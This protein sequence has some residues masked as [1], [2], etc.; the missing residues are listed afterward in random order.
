MV[1]PVTNGPLYTRTR[2]CTD[3]YLNGTRQFLK[4][5]T[6]NQRQKK[7]FNLPLGYACE[8]EEWKILARPDPVWGAIVNPRLAYDNGNNAVTNAATVAFGKFREACYG[9][10]AGWAVSVVQYRQTFDML[11]SNLLTLRNVV[12]HLSRYK[13]S[14]VRALHRML[15]PPP[16]FKSKAKTVAGRWLEWSFGIKP[17]LQDIG[18]SVEALKRDFD[19]K[20]VKV[21]GKGKYA[22]SGSQFLQTSVYQDYRG[23]ATQK[24]VMGGTITVTNPNALLWTSLGLTNPLAVV[25]D[26]IPYSFVLNYFISIEP[27]IQGLSP[28]YGVSL[29]N[30]YTSTKTSYSGIVLSRGDSPNT[31]VANRGKRVMTSGS[32]ETFTRAPGALATPPLRVR[33][34]WIISPTRAANAISLL[35]QQLKR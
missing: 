5:V 4:Q 15:K 21:H 27:W 32:R 19:T 23:V 1:A 26:A 6:V 2:A 22:Y 20:H 34:P 10:M 9:D 12:Y 30:T 16:G 8:T 35:I 11:T 31:P 7:P 17:I 14:N 29:S 28:W 33:D 13:A 18:S 25:Y 3:W 24:V